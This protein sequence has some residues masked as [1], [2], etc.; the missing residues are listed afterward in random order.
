[1]KV[2]KAQARWGR[3]RL[4][5]LAL[6]S[7]A[8]GLLALHLGTLPDLL[9]SARLA[10]L[11]VVGFVGALFLAVGLLAFVCARLHRRGRRGEA[12]FLRHLL[13]P[14][15]RLVA[16]AVL[17]LLPLALAP[18]A[19]RLP[20]PPSPAAAVVV[21]PPRPVPL[22]LPPLPA[23]EVPAAPAVVEVPEAVA[24]APAP[25]VA[26]LP[27]DPAGGG[28]DENEAFRLRAEDLAVDLLPSVRFELDRYGVPDDRH[29]LEGRL[30]QAAVDVL[31]LWEDDAPTGSGVAVSFDMPT[32]GGPILRFS[33]LFLT[34]SGGE[35]LYEERGEFSLGHVTFD[36][37][38]SLAGGTRQA[39]LDLSLS[40]G[41]AVDAVEDAELGSGARLSPHL[42]VDLALWQSSRVGLTFHAGQTLPIGLTGGAAAV[43][44][45]AV[46]L[47]IDL[48]E[49]ISLR[50]GWR[51]IVV[52]L[53]DYEGSF[54]SGDVVAEL[55]RELSGPF[56]GLDIRF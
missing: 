34:L 6:A 23:L 52:H 27:P 11:S 24:A 50:A 10:L 7:A 32:E 17:L 8:A 9:P 42:A 5:V 45:L 18:A 41:F 33:T 19:F 55:D 39:A 49:N 46:G 21:R 16:P 15:E 53:R 20:D 51:H 22:P 35:E 4:F 54:A 3:R 2:R 14:A 40:L 37:V 29:P 26:P 47:R 25:A 13:E 43:T 1:M 56:V 28:G 30:L 38:F 36:A 44:D 31:M 48:S 12:R